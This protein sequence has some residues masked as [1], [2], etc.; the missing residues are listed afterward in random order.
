MALRCTLD[1]PPAALAQLDQ[2]SERLH[3]PSRDALLSH[4]VVQGLSAVVAQLEAQGLD[5]RIAEHF[6]PLGGVDLEVAQ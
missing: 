2:L 1:L 4:L 5:S 6:A 3:H